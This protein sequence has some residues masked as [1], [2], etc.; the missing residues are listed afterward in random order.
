MLITGAEILSDGYG[1]SH[2]IMKKRPG[3]RRTPAVTA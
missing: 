3:F 1:L 2:L